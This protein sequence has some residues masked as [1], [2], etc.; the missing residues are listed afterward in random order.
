MSHHSKKIID[1]AKKHTPSIQIE[2]KNNWKRHH[3]ANLLEGSNNVGIELGVAEGIFSKRMIDSGKFKRFYGVDAYSD[4]HDTK[5]YIKALKHID[6]QNR[7]FSLLRMNFDS[8]LSLFEDNFFDLVYVDGYAHTGE[9]GG[10]TLIDWFKKV[11]PGGIL[12]G[13]DYHLDFPLVIWAVN[14][15]AKQLGEKVFL[16]GTEQSHYCTYPTWFIKKNSI[17]IEPKINDQL[18]EIGMKE[19]ERIHILRS[20]NL[21]FIKKLFYFLIN[22]F[23]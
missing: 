12:S 20:N 10:S 9:E 23:K 13:D 17:N 1:I 7:K 3:V 14:D 19:K 8:A 5:E 11:K 16:T 18:F 2:C 6:F 22:K 15:L 4:I 21:N